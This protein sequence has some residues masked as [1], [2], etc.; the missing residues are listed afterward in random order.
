MTVRTDERLR[1]LPNSVVTI[2]LDLFIRSDVDFPYIIPNPNTS[3]IHRVTLGL[4]RKVTDDHAAT[5]IA[6]EGTWWIWD[7]EPSL[8]P[9]MPAR[10]AT[11]RQRAPTS[12]RLK[13]LE[14]GNAWFMIFGAPGSLPFLVPK[15]SGVERSRHVCQHTCGKVHTP[16]HS[17]LDREPLLHERDCFT[18][19]SQLNWKTSR[20]TIMRSL[21]VVDGD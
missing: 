18:G 20:M 5:V 6:S 21:S 17:L 13:R 11:R 12:T 15:E 1:H 8:C 16:D 19:L 9:A 7:D 4:K 10:A 14:K 2:D 3:S